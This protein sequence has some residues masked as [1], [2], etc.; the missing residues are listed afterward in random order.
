MYGNCLILKNLLYFTELCYIFLTKTLIFFKIASGDGN[1]GNVNFIMS[2]GLLINGAL[3]GNI[4]SSNLVIMLHSG[5]YDYHEHGVKNVIK[6]GDRRIKN[7][8]NQLGNYDY[9][10]NCLKDDCAIL[11]IDQRN[12]GKSGKNIDIEKMIQEIK[13]INSNINNSII[14][15]IIDCFLKNDKK[16]LNVIVESLNLNEDEKDKMAVLIKRPIIKDMSFL[17]MKDDL[18]EVLQQLKYIKSFPNIHLVGTCMGGLVASLYAIENPENIKSLTLFSP[19]LA[20]DAVFLK[21]ESEFGVKKFNIINSGGQFRMGNAVEGMN[22]Q[23]EIE[24]ISQTF[25]KK[26]EQLNIPTLC[27]Q[28]MDDALIPYMEQ[29]KIFYNFIKYKD[30]HNLAPVYYTQIDNAVHCLYNGIFPALMEVTNFITSN[31][32]DEKQKQNKL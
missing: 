26:F 9:L 3:I 24:F 23:K 14:K 2:D 6:D 30:E 19:L 21:P 16:K 22:T 17:Q 11:L 32:E 8:Y 27:I 13:R 20:F 25:Y 7:Y 12:H 28:G 31:F 4:E 29:N 1:M 15:E 5:G 18:V 10:S